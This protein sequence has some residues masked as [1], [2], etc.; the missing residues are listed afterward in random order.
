MV[1][2]AA[3]ENASRMLQSNCCVFRT[4]EKVVTHKYDTYNP[5]YQ[6]RNDR[7]LRQVAKPVET[8]L[9]AASE[10]VLSSQRLPR[11]CHH[12]QL[13]VAAA[14]VG[15]PAVHLRG[16]RLQRYVVRRRSVC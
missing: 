8:S 16:H 7:G 9:A 5:M 3:S 12:V 15:G 4:V 11:R 14:N 2:A 6:D 10:G 1:G 13:R